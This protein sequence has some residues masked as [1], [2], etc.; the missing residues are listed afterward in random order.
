MV[1]Q[2]EA[3]N[4]KIFAKDENVGERQYTLI[5]HNI[6]CTGLLIT[7]GLYSVSFRHKCPL[8]GVRT[9]SWWGAWHWWGVS[10]R[11]LSSSWGGVRHLGEVTAKVHTSQPG[12]GVSSWTDS[13]WCVAGTWLT[14][15]TLGD[16]L[17]YEILTLEGWGGLVPG[18]SRK[19]PL[20]V[21]LVVYILTFTGP[22]LFLHADVG[23]GRGGSDFRDLMFLFFLIIFHNF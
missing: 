4:P 23:V 1:G 21:P 17:E 2:K 16:S 18:W 15:A 20:G 19:C 8:P 13:G 22:D 14:R 5:G 6:N 10:G 7:I 12:G 9:L 11:C 3:R